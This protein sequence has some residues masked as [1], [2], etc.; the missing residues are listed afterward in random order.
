VLIV[1]LNGPSTGS[2]AFA[3]GG[4]SSTCVIKNGD[5]YCWG[6]NRWGAL[7]IG[8]NNNQRSPILALGLER[9]N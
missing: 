8:G 6:S 7:G 4:W 2:T 9:G 5:I 3:N 1:N